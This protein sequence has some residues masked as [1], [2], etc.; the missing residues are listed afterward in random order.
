MAEVRL[1]P[2]RP[3]DLDF[4]TR[5]ERDPENRDF[6]GQWTDAEHLD[7]IAA[8]GGR[9]HWIIE[10]DGAPAGYLIV[11]DGSGEGTG[12]YVKRLLVAEKEK[13]TGKA[14]L[15]AFLDDAFARPGVEFVWLQVFDRNARAQAVYTRLGFVRFEVSGEDDARWQRVDPGREG[16][17]RMGIEASGWRRSRAR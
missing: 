12:L 14:A 5:L 9:E 11:F 8:R 16:I 2:T 13:G 10:R 7:A 3:D 6:I 15:A 4:V 1:R 17:W